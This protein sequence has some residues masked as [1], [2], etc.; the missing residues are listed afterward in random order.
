MKTYRNKWIEFSTGFSKVSF[1]I[2]PASYFDERAMINICLGWGQLFLHLPIKSGINECEYPQYG[3]YF[4]GEGKFFES[5]W[6]CWGRKNYCFY[7]PW[8]WE[9]VRTSNLR[10]DGTWEHEVNG[11][12]KNFYEDKWK[13][14]LWSE[15]YH[16]AYILKSGKIQ[17]R[18]A[19]IKVEEREWRWRWLINLPFP[20]IINKTIDINFN[21]EVGERTGSWKGGTLGCSYTM[22][23]GELPIHTLRRMERERKFN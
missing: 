13:D 18:I 5:F 19:T 2:S 14:I 3:F 1:K 16:Y 22:K 7:M 12:R 8:A 21:E 11:E 20:R 6:W 15:S 9:W 4:Y 17:E 23:S 10:K